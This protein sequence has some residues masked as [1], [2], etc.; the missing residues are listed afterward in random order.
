MATNPN[1]LTAAQLDRLNTFKEITQITD[2]ALG[3]EILAANSWNVE[4]SVNNFLA[5]RTTSPGSSSSSSS[6]GEHQ[7]NRNNAAV[8]PNN[9]ANN[10]NN[11][12]SW[13][14]LRWLFQ[15]HPVSL[16]PEIGY[17]SLLGGLRHEV[18]ISTSPI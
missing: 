2:D 14:P 8:V 9:N 7:R 15:T 3:A 16:N 11:N 1:N 5:G 6:S 18:R 10:A 12:G 4:A 13:N 17:S